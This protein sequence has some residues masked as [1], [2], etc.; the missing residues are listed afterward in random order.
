MGNQVWVCPMCDKENSSGTAVCSSCGFYLRFALDPSEAQGSNGLV[1]EQESE[2]Q[3][4]QTS[5]VVRLNP[6]HDSKPQ[7]TNSGAKL[8]KIARIWAGFFKVTLILAFIAGIIAAALAKSFLLFLSFLASEAVYAVFGYIQYIV[9]TATGDA[10]DNTFRI[11]KT[12]S[13]LS[14]EV[15]KQKNVK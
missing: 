3:D 9:L 5:S 15:K 7:Q 12:L 2:A 11:Q 13:S 1:P 14:K 6:N 4:V 10:A 8:K